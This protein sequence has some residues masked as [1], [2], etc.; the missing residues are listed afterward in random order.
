M[1]PKGHNKPPK[2]LMLKRFRGCN[3]Y[4]SSFAFIWKPFA[5]AL[6]YCICDDSFVLIELICICFSLLLIIPH[7]V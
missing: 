4:S 1:Y 2:A 7:S 6:F 3:I 5:N